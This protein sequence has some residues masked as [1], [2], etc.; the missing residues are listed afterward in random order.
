MG[1]ELYNDIALRG[2]QFLA[3]YVQKATAA[4]FFASVSVHT[5]YNFTCSFVKLKPKFTLILTL[6][7][8]YNYHVFTALMSESQKLELLEALS[9]YGLSYLSKAFGWP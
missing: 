1:F 7:A 8:E 9:K 6:S 2:L 5:I 3:A 4:I